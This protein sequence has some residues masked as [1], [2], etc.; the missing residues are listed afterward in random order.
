MSGEPSTSSSSE[1]KTESNGGG[2]APGA[3]GEGVL[4]TNSELRSLEQFHV[5][6]ELGE[7]SYSTV[8]LASTKKAGV[9]YALKICSKLKIQREKK[10][11]IVQLMATFHDESSLYFVLTYARYRDIAAK[12]ERHKFD[13]DTSRFVTAELV[14][15]CSRASC[16]TKRR[17]LRSADPRKPRKAPFFDG[18]EYLIFQRIANNRYVLD[19]NFPDVQAKDL[20]QGFLKHKQDERLGSPSRG[21]FDAIRSHPFFKSIDW[22]QLNKFA[23]PLS[24]YYQKSS[25]GA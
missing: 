12:M 21:G 13:L 2:D 9:R 4:L 14:L 15:A 6:E 16:W 10:P 18:S 8:Y 17:L 23:S 1:R 7:G 24:A 20:I 11:F 3:T 22:D 25:N 19:E 5:L